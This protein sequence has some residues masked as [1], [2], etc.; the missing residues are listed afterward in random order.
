MSDI[1]AEGLMKLLRDLRTKSAVGPGNMIVHM[2]M[3]EA[4]EAINTLRVALDA[5]EADITEMTR[6]RDEWRAKADGYDAV[7]LALRDAIAGKFGEEGP[8]KMSRI[9]WAGVAADEKKRADDAEA[10]KQR[11]VDAERERCA[12]IAMTDYDVLPSNCACRYGKDRA[13]S[14]SKWTAMN[15]V[16][17]IRA[18]GDEP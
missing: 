13:L 6:R 10:D 11:A 15:L 2:V 14:C 5:A 9:L 18:Q 12:G 17:T 1:S 16:A 3:D 7:R 4:W 8:L